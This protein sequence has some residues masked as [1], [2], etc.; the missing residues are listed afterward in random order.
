MATPVHTLGVCVHHA[1]QTMRLQKLQRSRLMLAA[2]AAV[3][4]CSFMRHRRLLLGVG[5]PPPPLR[6]YFRPTLQHRR[7]PESIPPVWLVAMPI[8]MKEEEE[9]VYREKG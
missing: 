7:H 4:V 2:A 1:L 9:E 8:A 6:P 5:R 3:V